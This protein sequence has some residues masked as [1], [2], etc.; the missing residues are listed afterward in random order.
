[1]KIDS[2]FKE[3]GEKAYTTDPGMALDC[4]IE[5]YINACGVSMGERSIASYAAYYWIFR[6]KEENPNLP[7]TLKFKDVMKLRSE[8]YN[9]YKEDIDKYGIAFLDPE[10][11]LRIGSLMLDDYADELS[12]IAL[13]MGIIFYLSYMME[14]MNGK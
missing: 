2:R 3:Y 11:I 10:E 1:M 6:Y 12:R 7:G 13:S 9:Q 8:E 14:K 5:I 4:L